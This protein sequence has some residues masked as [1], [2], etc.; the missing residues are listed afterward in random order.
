MIKFWAILLCICYNTVSLGA[1]LQ[2]HTCGNNML[3]SISKVENPH[4]SCPLCHSTPTDSCH[5]GAC[6]DLELKLDQ[7]SDQLFAN[8][9]DTVQLVDSAIIVLPWI[10]SPQERAF[11]PQ[12]DEARRILTHSNSSPPTYILHCTFRI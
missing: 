4:D 6:Q 11:L 9:K 12:L 8:S 3:W 10:R 5:G 2:I 7:L 1:T